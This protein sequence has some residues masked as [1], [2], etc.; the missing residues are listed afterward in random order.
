MLATNI[1]E[2]GVCAAGDPHPI[3]AQAQ[4]G[5]TPEILSW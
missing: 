1:G 3:A 2:G 5:V 4:T